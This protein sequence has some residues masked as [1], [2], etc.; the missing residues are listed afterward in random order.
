MRRAHRPPVS[1]AAAVAPDPAVSSLPLLLLLCLL[2][3][4]RLCPR[5]PRSFY[6]NIA[7]VAFGINTCI[8][9]YLAVWLPYVAKIHLEWAVY[10]PRMI[11]TATVMGLILSLIHI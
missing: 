8:T 2:L 3:T 9:L 5:P 11:P 1:P 7:V 4:P 6:F 10:C